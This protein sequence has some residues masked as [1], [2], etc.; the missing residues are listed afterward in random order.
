MAQ[1]TILQVLGILIWKWILQK[2]VLDFTILPEQCQCCRSCLN[3]FSLYWALYFSAELGRMPD[4]TGDWLN[5]NRKPDFLLLCQ[6]DETGHSL[7]SGLRVH[8]HAVHTQVWQACIWM[9][10][11]ENDH[12]K[13]L[14]GNLLM[15]SVCQGLYAKRRWTGMIKATKGHT[16]ENSVWNGKAQNELKRKC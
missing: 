11:A 12:L 2:Q 3:V 14:V 16:T 15:K 10:K 6:D 4:C 1:D 9:Y 5:K 8:V 13:C 7:S